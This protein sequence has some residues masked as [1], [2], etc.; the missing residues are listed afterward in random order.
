MFPVSSPISILLLPC[1]SKETAGTGGGLQLH[2]LFL[3]QRVRPTPLLEVLSLNLYFPLFRSAFLSLLPPQG[4]TVSS[5]LFGH[6]SSARQ[7]CDRE[8]H[9]TSTNF[10]RSTIG[11]TDFVFD[12]P[13][14]SQQ[15]M[16]KYYAS[17]FPFPVTI[18][19]FPSHLLPPPTRELPHE[20][21][22]SYS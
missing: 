12:D 3:M 10:V 21:L 15:W 5:L 17:S 13:P 2:P 14:V 7:V 18:S 11:P 20:S 1:A 6:P 8:H 19:P 9:L 4:C 16:P 22:R